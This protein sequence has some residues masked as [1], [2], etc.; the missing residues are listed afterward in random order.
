MPQVGDY[1]LAF[2]DAQLQQ[3]EGTDLPVLATAGPDSA[4]QP[5]S[6][7]AQAVAART[8]LAGL[9]SL[10]G[11]LDDSDGEDEGVAGDAGGRGTE[12]GA[13]GAVQSNVL[14]G[15]QPARDAAVPAVL[16]A[17]PP[18]PL[19]LVRTAAL[20]LPELKQLL[21]SHGFSVRATRAA[22]L[23]APVTSACAR[24][25]RLSLAPLCDARGS[26]VARLR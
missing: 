8:V 2:V 23:P 22:Q 19:L 13:V 20:K 6:P 7:R 18:R 5:S 21:A 1:S 4:P 9:A 14:G 25:L 15:V 12:P 3:R 17:A 24:Y 26:H 10:V 11:D 16:D